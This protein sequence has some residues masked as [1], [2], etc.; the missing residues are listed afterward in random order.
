MAR[1]ANAQRLASTRGRLQLGAQLG[2]DAIVIAIANNRMT[3]NRNW[4]ET[5]GVVENERWRGACRAQSKARLEIDLMPTSRLGATA[6]RT[7][8]SETV[9]PPSHARIFSSFVT[10]LKAGS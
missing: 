9:T 5:A 2:D 7:L 6:C 3:S 10:K 1:A 8:P 4:V